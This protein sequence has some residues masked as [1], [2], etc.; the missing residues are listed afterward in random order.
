MPVLGPPDKKQQTAHEDEVLNM[1][2]STRD[3][4][5]VYANDEASEAHDVQIP[6]TLKVSVF[7]SRK[8]ANR[9]QQFVDRDNHAFENE[10]AGYR[11]QWH[12]Q[13]A[14]EPD[15]DGEGGAPLGPPPPYEDG[16][17]GYVNGQDGDVKV[18]NLG[19]RD[20]AVDVVIDDEEVP[21]GITEVPG[22]ASS[23][24][25]D[26][27]SVSTVLPGT[28]MGAVAGGW[29][30]DARREGGKALREKTAEAASEV[31][32]A[33]DAAAALQGPQA[34]QGELSEPSFSDVEMVDGGGAVDVPRSLAAAALPRAV[35]PPLP[36]RDGQAALQA[37][38]GPT[39]DGKDAKK[40]RSWIKNKITK[41]GL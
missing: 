29:A 28:S 33:V 34:Q 35:P 41:K 26:S 9:R 6:E 23:A 31:L 12:G 32:R 3:L 38:K 10:Q 13:S 11:H 2:R 39:A 8:S 36:P 19:G 15:S 16:G 1:A 30:P 20:E 5:L 14:F 7:W 27:A 18:D 25:S 22:L 21:T 4:T 40:G 37:A 17:P 24:V